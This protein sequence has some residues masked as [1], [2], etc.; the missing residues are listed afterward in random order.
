MEQMENVAIEIE[1]E[2]QNSLTKEVSSKHIR[3]SRY[4]KA[5]SYQRSGLC[6]LRRLYIGSSKI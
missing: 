3:R 1:S 5:E 6:P 2:L 4:G